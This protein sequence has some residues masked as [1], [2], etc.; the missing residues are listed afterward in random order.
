M[1]S[2]LSVASGQT[3]AHVRTCGQGQGPVATATRQL[4]DAQPGNVVTLVG[5]EGYW[6]VTYRHLGGALVIEEIRKGNGPTRNFEVLAHDVEMLFANMNAATDYR[7]ATAQAERRAKVRETLHG[8]ANYCKG[9]AKGWAGAKWHRDDCPAVTEEQRFSAAT[10]AARPQLTGEGNVWG[11]VQELRDAVKAHLHYENKMG[12]RHKREGR[13]AVEVD[14]TLK[15][16]R[17]K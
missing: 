16:L 5:R 10:P 2:D 14:G 1:C 8:D 12:G 9:C 17:I 15:F 13:F 7:I 11:P 3:V 6:L 4:P